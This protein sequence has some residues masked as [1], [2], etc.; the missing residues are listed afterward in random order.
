[1]SVYHILLE[2]G[3]ALRHII[4]WTC[5]Q[6]KFRRTE[7]RREVGPGQIRQVVAANLVGAWTKEWKGR[8]GKAHRLDVIMFDTAVPV[9]MHL[10]AKEQNETNH[11]YIWNRR[12]RTFSL[13]P[14]APCE[15]TVATATSTIF[16]LI[17]IVLV[18]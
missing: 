13:S 3:N 9:T 2:L 17:F 10:H 16:P 8:Q 1:M 6:Q 14:N 7:A 18:L 4:D 5:V 15:E 11:N 12:Y